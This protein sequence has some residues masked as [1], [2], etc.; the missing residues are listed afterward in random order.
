[1]E[2]TTPVLEQYSEVRNCYKNR[3]IGRA[4]LYKL[5][6]NSPLVKKLIDLD[7]DISKKLMNEEI[8]K[9]KIKVAV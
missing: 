5:N 9:Q 8:N 1:M 3:K 6:L 4:E 7:M 2:H